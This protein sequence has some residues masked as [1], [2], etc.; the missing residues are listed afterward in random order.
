[1]TIADDV[2]RALEAYERA[3]AAFL[4][5]DTEIDSAAYFEARDYLEGRAP[6]W[7]RALL[8]ENARLA[9][10]AHAGRLLWASVAFLIPPDHPLHEARLHYEATLRTAALQAGEGDTPAE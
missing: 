8:D 6:E 5:P 3:S 4:K 1:M 2:R 10:E 9:A 7:L